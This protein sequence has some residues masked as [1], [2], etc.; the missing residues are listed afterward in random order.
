MLPH[1]SVVA[2][3]LD[4][5]LVAMV[6]PP[7]V[8]EGDS[9]TKGEEA[10]HRPRRKQEAEAGAGV[11]ERIKQQERQTHWR[12]RCASQVLAGRLRMLATRN[13]RSPKKGVRSNKL[14]GRSCLVRHKRMSCPS[15]AD[16][17]TEYAAYDCHGVTYY[18][19]IAVH[20]ALAS[21]CAAVSTCTSAGTSERLTVDGSRD[22]SC[23]A[24]LK[25]A[26]LTSVVRY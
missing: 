8:N 21:R 25:A 11:L 2:G 6:F 23:T 5:L 26:C 14:P 24:S 3:R 22:I 12:E 15:D 13:S 16:C 7:C 19:A 18:T 9:L 17:L 10:P 1:R 4:K 20:R